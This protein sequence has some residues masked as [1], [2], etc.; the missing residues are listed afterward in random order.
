MGSD[1]ESFAVG[2]LA[3]PAKIVVLSFKNRKEVSNYTTLTI[4]VCM[5]LICILCIYYAVQCTI[6]HID[7]YM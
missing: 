3:T 4:L 1:L 6:V 2:R 7:E 5:I